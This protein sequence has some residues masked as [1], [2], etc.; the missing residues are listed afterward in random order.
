M[1]LRSCCYPSIDPNDRRN[2]QRSLRTSQIKGT[3][4]QLCSMT[5]YLRVLG[6]KRAMFPPSS[7]LQMVA[8]DQPS[9]FRTLHGPRLDC[10]THT[11]GPQSYDRCRS[12]QSIEAFY[13]LQWPSSVSI[14][15]QWPAC[16]A[17]SHKEMSTM[18]SWNV[19]F[20]FPE[21]GKFLQTTLDIVAALVPHRTP[22]IAAESLSSVVPLQ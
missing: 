4:A 7:N 1:R 9:G 14:S 19:V 22:Y 3:R 15:K 6:S 13:W 5:N 16:S 11:L 10:Y 21:H 8:L 12:K 2:T 18:L 20:K 17:M